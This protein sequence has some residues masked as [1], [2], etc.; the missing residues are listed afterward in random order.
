MR[1]ELT[2]VADRVRQSVMRL[3]TE[4]HRAWAKDEFEFI[5][6][7]LEST[8]EVVDADVVRPATVAHAEAMVGQ[9]SALAQAREDRRSVELK[10]PPL[11]LP[12]RLM[13][14]LHAELTQSDSSEPTTTS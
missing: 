8:S 5:E 1:A 14:F 9:I 7:T 3:D 6:R 11:L 4:E 10:K 2:K 13:K 12:P